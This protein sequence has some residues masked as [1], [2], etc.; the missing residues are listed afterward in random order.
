VSFFF[1]FECFIIKKLLK[2]LEK[3]LVL[4]NLSKA[5]RIGKSSST[6]T[7]EH[8]KPTLFTWALVE[9]RQFHT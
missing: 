5:L 1:F 4:Q 2:L 8:N 3:I 9:G 6:K 7:F